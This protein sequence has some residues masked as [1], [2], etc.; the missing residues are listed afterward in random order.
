MDEKGMLSPLLF[1]ILIDY[2]VRIANEGSRGDIQWGISSGRVEY[3]DDLAYADDLAVLACTQAQIRDK[4]DKVWKVASSLGLEIN[5]PKTKSTCINTT[6][7]APLT[8]SGETLECVE[9]F[10]YRG[11][12]ISSDGSAQKDK[13]EAFHNGCLR[14]I[15]LKFEVA[16]QNK[17]RVNSD[18]N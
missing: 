8:V 2:V 7:D 5:A 10:T 14:R 12:V 11:S 13:I 9:S 3:L 18:N 1:L 17:F 6:L 16:R 15:H 4:A